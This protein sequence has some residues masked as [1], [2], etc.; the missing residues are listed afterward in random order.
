[1]ICS[2][3]KTNIRRLIIAFVVFVLFMPLCVDAYA[4]NYPDK[5][6]PGGRTTGIKL[7]AEGAVV[8]GFSSSGAPA[9]TAGIKIGDV[10]VA[11]DGQPVFDKTTLVGALTNAKDK[12]VEITVK[13]NGQNI[14]MDVSALH[15]S[16]GVGYTIGASVKDTIAGIGTVTYIVPD[17]GEYGALGHGI[18]DP[19]TMSLAPFDEGV[20]M[21]S[22]VISVKKGEEG[23]PG[24]L[25]GSYEMSKV[26][27][28]VKSNT[29]CGIFGK[30]NDSSGFCDGECIPIAE[31]N[32]IKKGKASILSNITDNK[33]DSYDIEIVDI[34]R[35]NTNMKQM[36]IKVTDPDLLSVTG[37]IVQGMSG[38]P[39]IQDGKLVG[40]VTHVLVNDP[41][42][43]YGI[44][45]ENMLDAAG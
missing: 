25:I 1:M 27:G 26:Q 9:K 19:E 15:D 45:I 35:K 16:T 43:G 34:D 31:L 8:T 23:T 41:T 33:V 38:S 28:S 10:I 13:R 29:N 7:Y 17:S 37:G 6:I 24:E 2:I 44:F 3:K 21:P 30:L 5:L 11:V 18:T 22:T 42:R 14:T 36:L 32:D 4:A 39:I 40:A 20:L 12:D